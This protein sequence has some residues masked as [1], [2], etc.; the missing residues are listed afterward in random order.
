M[1]VK[2]SHCEPMTVTGVPRKGSGRFKPPTEA[3]KFFYC[4]HK[5]TVQ[6]LLLN[7]FN[8]KFCTEKR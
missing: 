8:P 4:L 6:A 1:R 3:S 7:F 5:N 2:M